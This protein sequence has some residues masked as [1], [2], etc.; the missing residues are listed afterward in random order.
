MRRL[1]IVVAAAAIAAACLV[2]VRAEASTTKVPHGSCVSHSKLHVSCFTERRSKTVTAK[3]TFTGY[4]PADLQSMYGVTP[5]MLPTDA[6]VGIVD[7]GR[8]P[9][10]ESELATYRSHFDLP[11]CTKANGCFT[12]YVADGST[13]PTANSGWVG[14]ITLDVE[15][16]SAVCPTCRIALMDASDASYKAIFA[17]IS[18]LADQGVQYISMSFGMGEWSGESHYNATFTR[19]GTI[20]VAAS[21]DDGFDDGSDACNGV[22]GVCYPAAAPGV[23]AVGGIHATKSGSMWKYSAWAGSGSG[24]AHFS[25][26]KTAQKAMTLDACHGGEAQADV[27]ALADPNTGFAAYDALD[28]WYVVGGT[29]LASPIVASLYAIAGNNIDAYSFT[30][31][32][33]DD[34][35]LADV[36]SGSTTGCDGTVLCTAGKGWDGATGIG[37]PVSPE[38]FA[39][40]KGG[41]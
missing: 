19:P 32:A 21:G 20:F 17:A 9:N 11:S 27:S 29:S 36:T 6:T 35:L 10:V 12:E 41:A 22:V 3:S 25:K 15:A 7:V 30:R 34:S 4:A 2:N 5:V 16:V 24:C 38:F 31:N 13:V 37:T 28:G 14:E 39:D 33:L 18:T 8:D 23:I 40:R 1:I 26:A